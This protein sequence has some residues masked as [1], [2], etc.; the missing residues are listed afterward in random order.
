MLPWT[1][2]YVSLLS[3]CMSLGTRAT[4]FFCLFFLFWVP[5]A[6]IPRLHAIVHSPTLPQSHQCRIV[7]KIPNGPLI[8]LSQQG[9]QAHR[10]QQKEAGHAGD[11][12]TSRRRQGQ[13]SVNF[14]TRRP[15]VVI[16]NTCSR[17]PAMYRQ[18]CQN[19]QGIVQQYDQRQPTHHPPAQGKL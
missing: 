18:L 9:T 13:F 3:G 17:G 7:P 1:I 6:A 15:G 10:D 2:Q 14:G 4:C 19:H 16:N 11:N 12:E 8:P 5:P